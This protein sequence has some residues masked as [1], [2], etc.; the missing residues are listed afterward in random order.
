MAGEDEAQPGGGAAATVQKN[1]MPTFSGKDGE[2]ARWWIER[3]T[4]FG[5][6]NNLDDKAIAGLMDSCLLDKART[7]WVVKQ[8]Y[9][10]KD[11]DKWSEI[12]KLIE[13]R[14]ISEVSHGDATAKMALLKQAAGETVEDFYDRCEQVTFDCEGA[15]KPTSAAEKALFTMMH[16]RTVARAFLSGLKEEVAKITKETTEG[17]DLADLKKAAN[18]AE[19]ALKSSSTGIC[20]VTQAKETKEETPSD[21]EIAAMWRDYKKGN[22]KKSGG[23]NNGSSS[24]SSNNGTKPKNSE[25]K[26]GSNNRG[27]NDRKPRDM[28]KI[29]CFRCD[30]WGHISRECPSRQQQ[31]RQASLSAMDVAAA[32]SYA[33]MAAKSNFTS[34]GFSSGFP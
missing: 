11:L 18:R 7:W 29:Q 10:T 22:W 14:W 16:E 9:G 24:S 12:Q 26:G 31:Q 28:A 20:S 13:G 21:A 33:A 2:D 34:S 30:Q 15:V 19:K 1:R 27:K 4:A 23:S 25:N 3:M 6:A 8:K 32:S 17:N 5:T